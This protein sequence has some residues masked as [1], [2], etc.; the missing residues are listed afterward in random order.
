MSEIEWLKSDNLVCLFFKLF[1]VKLMDAFIFVMI[2]FL[3]FMYL[4]IQVTYKKFQITGVDCSNSAVSRD[5]LS[6]LITQFIASSISIESKHIHTTFP[7]D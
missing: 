2:P 3:A 5:V 4:L 1:T 6:Y 7:W